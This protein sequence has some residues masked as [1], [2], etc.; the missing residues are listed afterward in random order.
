MIGEQLNRRP[1]TRSRTYY[2]DLRD[3]DRHG[4]TSERHVHGHDSAATR[5][6][7]HDRHPPGNGV[8]SH[9]KECQ[10]LTEQVRAIYQNAEKAD[11]DLTPAERDQVEG[12]LDAAEVQAK[13]ESQWKSITSQFGPT[14]AS[15][16]GED[17]S[18][19]GSGAGPGDRFVAS[20]AYARVKSPDDRAQWFSTGPIQVSDGPMSTKG[21]LLESSG[22]DGPVAA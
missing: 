1:L 19:W 11:R 4:G 21:T 10:Q 9:A 5:C 18:T 20:P 22:G 3:K 6:G 17:I 16:L 12:L 15:T 7:R 8:V 2:R 14:G 13:A